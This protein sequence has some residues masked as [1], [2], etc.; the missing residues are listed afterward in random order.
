MKGA[1]AFA[2]FI[3]WPSTRYDSRLNK[4]VFWG[5]YLHLNSAARLAVKA[6]DPTLLLPPLL[7]EI[8]PTRR[9]KLSRIR[10][11]RAAEVI[12]CWMVRSWGDS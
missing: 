2:V 11:E 7:I 1:I 6:R 10:Q 4:D 5:T 12:D 3:W 9:S 8:R